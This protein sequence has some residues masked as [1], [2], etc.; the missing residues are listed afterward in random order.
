M[1]RVSFAAPV[2]A[3]GQCPFAWAEM[4]VARAV[5]EG[6][7]TGNPPVTVTFGG[8]HAWH[9]NFCRWITPVLFPLRNV[10]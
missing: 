7:Y 2:P 8:R 9:R 5:R 10:Q 6:S 1:E 3:T 4:A